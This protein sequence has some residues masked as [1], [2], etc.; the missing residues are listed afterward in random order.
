MSY[1]FPLKLVKEMKNLL[2]DVNSY[3]LVW[4]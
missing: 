2:V 3:G 1:V 4:L